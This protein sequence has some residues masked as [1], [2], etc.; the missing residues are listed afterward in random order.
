[1]TKKIVRNLGLVGALSAAGAV[2]SSVQAIDLLLPGSAC[3]A[4]NF[5]GTNVSIDHPQGLFS[6]NESSS[7][8]N[9]VC[10]TVHAANYFVDYDGDMAD[11]IEGVINVSVS[12]S[13]VR[14]SCTLLL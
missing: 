3:K 7:P 9:V 1:M 14:S 2:T 8:V 11:N 4:Q 13:W 6:T 5:Q 10:P 12:T